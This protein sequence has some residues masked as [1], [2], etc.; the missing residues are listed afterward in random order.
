[1]PRSLI[2]HVGGLQEFPSFV[3]PAFR[4]VLAENRAIRTWQWE[5]IPGQPPQPLVHFFRNSHVD[6]HVCFGLWSAL[7]WNA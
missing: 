7:H 3:V 4:W 2:G 6:S 5:A 1:M